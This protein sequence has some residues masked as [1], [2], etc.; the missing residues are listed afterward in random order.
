MAAEILAEVEYRDIPGLDGYRAGS[1]G[2][3]W[4]CWRRGMPK[5][6]RPGM[7]YGSEKTNEWRQ[8]RGRI[9]TSRGTYRYFKTRYSKNKLHAIHRVVLESF[10]GPR[11][12][13]QECRHLNGNPLDNRLE[14][15]CW[16]T[17]KENAHDAIKHGTFFGKG[18]YQP[19]ASDFC[20]IDGCDEKHKAKGYCQNHYSKIIGNELRRIRR[21]RA[22]GAEG[23]V[24]PRDFVITDAQR[25]LTVFRE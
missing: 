9:A 23:D 18:N 21:K 12:E 16:G 2:T 3:V 4:S 14:N 6:A 17:R 25:F 15:L 10:V 11:P 13:G 22:R 7:A 24:L 5:G 1:D 19:S 20:V 8:V